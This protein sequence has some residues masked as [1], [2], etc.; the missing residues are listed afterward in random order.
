MSVAIEPDL[1][2]FRGGY[3]TQETVERAY[4]D[5]DLT[6]AIA[7]YKFFYPTVSGQAIF[8]GSYATGLADNRIAGT[9]AGQPKHVG[10]TYNSD[11]PYGPV[12]LNLKEGPF[13]VEIPAGPLIVVAL[14]AN[15]RWVGDMGIPGPDG[16]KGGKY[17]ILPPGYTGEVPAGCYPCQSTSYHVIVG[18]RSL[19]LGGD[20]EAAMERIKTV[21]VRPLS[22]PPDWAG[23][24]WYDQTPRPQDTTPLAYETS[25]GFW[26]HLHSLIDDDYP[27]EGYR[28]YYGELAVLG[29]AKG[30]PFAPDER[31]KHILENA[32]RIANAQLRVQSFADRRP[33]R[34][35]WPGRQWEWAA[36][37]FENGDF[38]MPGYVDLDAR[39]KWFF[40]AIG[41]SP[42]MFRRKEGFGSLY[43]LGHRDDAGAYLD[44]GRTYKLTI[45]QPVPARLF[46][47]VTVY[48]ALT[49]AE[50][51]TDQDCAALR[52]LFELRDFPES[53]P[54]DLYFGPKGPAGKNKPWVKTIPGEGWFTY[55]RIYGPE[56]PAFDG[57]W[58]PGD[59]ERV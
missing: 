48:S 44:G 12:L 8:R 52:S 29:I 18:I 32:A 20:V 54:I 42:A 28:G 16:G 56:A 58:K 5:A 11:T 36:L 41:A 34:V 59:F 26:E 50:I 49:R 14:D 40:Q 30:Q 46:W 37:R 23:I 57:S 53:R 17:I 33:D 24:T 47:S 6:R 3:P 7:A 4:D 39:D 1:Y 10:F 51:Q 9:L 45:P 2:E 27:Y 35:V 38:D 43:W 22:P 55:L 15:Q 21:G 25:L 19:P 13:I 31:M